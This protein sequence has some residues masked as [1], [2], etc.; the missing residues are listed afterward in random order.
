MV[1]EL[2]P[3]PPRRRR[4]GPWAGEEWQVAVGEGTGRAIGTPCAPGFVIAPHFHA[5]A[6]TTLSPLS[7]TQAFFARWRCTPSTCCPHGSAGT[8]A[9]LG[10]VVA[11]TSSATH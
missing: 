5:D 4:D 8:S 1:P 2:D 11:D 3:G 6:E 9:A 10:R 7:D